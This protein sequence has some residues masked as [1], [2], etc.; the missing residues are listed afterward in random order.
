MVDASQ[1]DSR[2]FCHNARSFTA[3]MLKA[4]FKAGF[5]RA[6]EEE[7]IGAEGGKG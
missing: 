3:L 1:P 4:G 6:A 2:S 5:Y 7:C